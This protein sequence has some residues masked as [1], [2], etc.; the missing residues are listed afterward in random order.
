MDDEGVKVALVTGSAAGIGQA[1]ASRL[2]R[3][4][5]DIVIADLSP[6]PDTERAVKAA[7]RNCL[8]VV[9][10]VSDHESVGR[11]A[12]AVDQRFGRCD[13]VVNNAG[14]QPVKPFP[15]IDLDTWNRVL[16][17]NV[18]SMFLICQAFLPYMVERGWGRVINQGSNSVGSTVSSF[19]SY[20]TS[21]GAVIAFSRALASEY[22]PAGVTVN[23]VA[24]GLTKTETVVNRGVGASGQPIQEEFDYFLGVQAIKHTATPRDMEGVVS[25]LASEDAGFITGQTLVVDGGVWRL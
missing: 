22:G 2:A 8:A 21:K 4:G 24:P 18:T 15:E 7:G 14:I 17:I 1:Y 3:D 11:L 16:A 20:M 23:T 25:F 19:T 6:A 10:D 12:G 5:F 13:V 9:C